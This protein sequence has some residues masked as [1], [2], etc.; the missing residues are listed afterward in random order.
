MLGSETKSRNR[1]NFKTSKCLL[2]I[3]RWTLTRQP[4]SSGLTQPVNRERSAI[5]IA[6][7]ISD[8]T[9]EIMI[10]VITMIIIMMIIMP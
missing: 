6:T 2:R 5:N 1:G 3:Q 9:T 7:K 4:E 8:I 10:T